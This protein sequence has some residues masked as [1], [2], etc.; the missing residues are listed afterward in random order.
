MKQNCFHIILAFFLCTLSTYAQLDSIQ[1]LPEVLLTDSKFVHFSKG[2]KLEKLNDSIIERNA[3]S[4]T[5]TLRYNSSIYFKENGSGMVSSPSFRGT[6][7]AQTAVIWNGI[8]INSV[9]TGQTDFNTISPLNYDEISIRSGGG[10]V[11]YGSG[12]VGGSIHLN[13][14]FTFEKIDTTQITINHG[15]FST[16]GGNASTTQAWGDHYLNVGV[17]FISSENDYNYIEKNQKN[18]HGEFLRFAAKV[19]EARRLKNGIATWN[20][21]YTYNDR[22]FSGSLNT[23]GKDKYKDLSTRNLWQLHQTF[24]AFDAKASVAHLFEQ[25]RYFPDSEKQLYDEGRANTFIGFFQS[26]VLLQKKFRINGKVEYSYINAE[27]DNVGENSRKTLATVLLLNHKVSDDFS[28]GLN[29]RKEF[30]ND[31][32]NPFLFSADAKWKVSKNYALRLNGSKNYRIPTFNDL[33]WYAGGNHNLQPET[34]YQVELGQEFWFGKLKADLAAYFISSEDLIKWI[35]G[36]G[37]IWEPVNITKTRNYGVEV[38]FDYSIK[39]LNQHT[40]GFTANYSYTNAEDLEKEKQ[41]IYVPFHKAAGTIQYNYKTLMVYFQGLYNGEA[42]TTTDNSS[43]V[44]GYKV[45][46]LGTEF[47]IPSNPQITFGI[48]L[49]N[50]FNVYYENVAYRPMPSRN[51][52]L[53]LKFNI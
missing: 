25:Y 46:N 47:T 11:Q 52:Q 36:N 48:R 38:T 12:A 17:D 35:P 51:I 33:Y 40:L 18:K 1:Q 6:N 42:Y 26:E 8:N 4:L 21:E 13:N 44:K 10:G 45:F 43:A 3:T 23:I 34:S 50:M 22:N 16:I 5:E 37:G 53:F 28:Y 9:F 14:T 30:L 39:L 24:G 41:L 31:F 32:D 29:F 7:A 49:K 15:S 20:S 2:F 19:N 27:G